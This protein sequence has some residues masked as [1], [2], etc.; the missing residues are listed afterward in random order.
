MAKEES[1]ISPGR[2][3]KMALNAGVEERSV[4]GLIR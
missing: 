1:R 4:G 2:Q 3:H